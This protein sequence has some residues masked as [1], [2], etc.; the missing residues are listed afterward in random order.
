[1]ITTMRENDLKLWQMRYQ[2]L[3]Y[4]S[5]FFLWSIPHVLPVAPE[6]IRGHGYSSSC[7]W[8]SLGVI[9]FECL[10]GSAS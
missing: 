3:Q 5:N 2:F 7:D 1:M 8:W 9:M 10:F 4:A 6:V